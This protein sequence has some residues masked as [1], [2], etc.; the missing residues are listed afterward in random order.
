MSCNLKIL[1]AADDLQLTAINFSSVYTNEVEHIMCLYDFETDITLLIN[2]FKGE[3]VRN[4]EFYSKCVSPYIYLH[5]TSYIPNKVTLSKM[6]LEY[7]GYLMNDKN[8]N[9]KSKVTKTFC[10][11]SNALMNRRK[12][13]WHRKRNQRVSRQSATSVVESFCSV[14]GA[15]KCPISDK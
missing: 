14:D 7:P 15:T 9:I 3:D 12:D 1:Y 2:F 13:F 10:V 5:L 6:K 8:E 11:M 4:L